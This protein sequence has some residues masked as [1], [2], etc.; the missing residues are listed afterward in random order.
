MKMFWRRDY[1]LYEGCWLLLLLLGVNCGDE[2]GCQLP[3]SWTGSWFLSG[4][5]ERI[6]INARTLGWLGNC[7]Q[8]VKVRTVALL[9]KLS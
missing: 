5:P 3:D 6:R 9:L 4:H 7:H 2:T 8:R 1:Y